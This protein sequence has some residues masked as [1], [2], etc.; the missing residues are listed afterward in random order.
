MCARVCPVSKLFSFNICNLYI[1]SLQILG[2]SDSLFSHLND[3]IPRAHTDIFK[4]SD[5]VQPTVQKLS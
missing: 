3:N 5:F 1:F 2:R 4:I